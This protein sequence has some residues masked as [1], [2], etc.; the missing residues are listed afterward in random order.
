MQQNGNPWTKLVVPSRDARR[1]NV[2]FR[3]SKERLT[4]GINAER[5]VIRQCCT[6]PRS[7]RLFPDAESNT[8]RRRKMS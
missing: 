6:H 5:G 3:T 7:V 1:L 8:T 4:N 2:N